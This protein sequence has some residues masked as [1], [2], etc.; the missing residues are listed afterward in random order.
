MFRRSRTGSYARNDLQSVVNRVKKWLLNFTASKKKLLS[1]NHNREPNLFFISMTDANHQKKKRVFLVSHIPSD[2][3]LSDN[4]E[5]PAR[6]S[7]REVVS[8]CHTDIF[9]HHI[10]KS[11]NR[12]SIGN[13][14][15]VSFVTS[16]MYLQILD[17]IQRQVCNFISFELSSLIYSFS[18]ASTCLPASLLSIF[19]CQLF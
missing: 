12:K 11:T 6:S 5:Q 3:K 10:Y 16:S 2:M 14:W 18:F 13:C 1:F 4:I 8:L 15:H 17:K 7:S 9:S 19:S